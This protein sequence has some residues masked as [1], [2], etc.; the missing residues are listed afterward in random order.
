MNGSPPPAGG[1]VPPPP[2]P[3]PPPGD[4]RPPGAFVVLAVLLAIS[5]LASV[6][7]ASRVAD[8]DRGAREA[9]RQAQQLHGELE[10]LRS[11]SPLPQATSSAPP[12]S[13]GSNAIEQIARAVERLRGLTFEQGIKPEVLTPEALRA[14]VEQQIRTETSREDIEI[15]DK[16][17]TALG[18]LAPGDDLYQISLEVGTEQVAG[19]YDDEAKKLVVAG[20]A[21]NLT[22]YDRVL[23]AH[24]LTHALT[25]QRFGFDALV[26]LEDERKDDEATAYLSLIEGDAT[27]MMLLYREEVLTADERRQMDRQ[28]NGQSSPELDAA[29]PVIRESLLFPYTRGAQFAN[30][31]YQ[32]GGTAELDR[33][34]LSPPT[35]TEQIMHPAR[36][37]TRDEPQPVTMPDVGKALGSG[38]RAI[39]EGGI[40]EFDALLIADQFLPETDARD[41]AAGWDGGR[42]EAFDSSKGTLVAMST[43]WDSAGEA[44][45]AAEAFGDWMRPRFGSRGS[46]YRDGSAVGWDSPSGAA[47]VVRSGSKVIVIVGPDRASVA[48]ARRAFP[49]AG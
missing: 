31:L 16:V 29:P 7:L 28:A 43:V 19:Y 14:R 34:Y 45:Q 23:T 5:L 22:P 20:S 9:I 44:R 15:S 33:A 13:F 10:R 18:L 40:G 30:A 47:E 21:S 39:D 42:Y 49:E 38:W 1:P 25:D 24:E 36:Y 11:A 37:F 17:L 35:S 3:P 26:A 27:L 41:A 4:S 6:T 12:G 8:A 46:G 48:A 2:F 32:R